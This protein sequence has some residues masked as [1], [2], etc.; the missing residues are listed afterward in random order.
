M[1][2]PHVRIIR[3]PYE[4]PHHSNLVLQ[5][6]NGRSHAQIEYYMNPASLV[7]WADHF[8]VFPR[9]SSDVFLFERGSE[10]PEDRWAYYLRFRVFLKDR[11]VTAHC[12]FDSTTTETC[13][14]ERSR[15]FAWTR[16]PH[17]STAWA[18]FVASLRRS[19]TPFWIGGS[20]MGPC[21]KRRMISGAW[22]HLTKRKRRSTSSRGMDLKATAEPAILSRYPAQSARPRDLSEVPEMD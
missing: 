22:M 5:V 20:A 9:H 16:R 11:L 19:I 18:G 13:P 6:C 12:M 1:I 15:S 21:M 8:E 4:E 10:R 7:D 14:R 3:F 2:R 17:R